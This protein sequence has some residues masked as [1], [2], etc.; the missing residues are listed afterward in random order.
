MRDLLRLYAAML[1]AS[2]A[3]QLQYRVALVIWLLGLVIQPVVYLVVWSAVAGQG[4]VGGYTRGD[5][6]AYYLTMMVVNHL[7][8]TWIMWEYD[9][10]IRQGQLSAMLLKPANPVHRLAADNMAYKLLTSVVVLPVAVLLGLY[11]RPTFVPTPERV[12]LFVA[13][14]TGAWVL[15]WLLEY[16]LALAAFWTTRVTALNELYYGLFWFLA[17]QVAP[18]A[19]LPGAVQRAAELLPFRYT[20]GF[21]VELLLGRLEGVQIAWGFTAQLVWIALAFGGYRLFW[22]AGLRRYSAVG[23]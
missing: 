4:A 9:Y 19:L 3:V 11:F 15:R 20:V 5:F 14:V 6:A 13:A 1:Q 10:L 12:V 23:G 7:T 2:I 16:T 8:F 17:G 21:P 22:R 18:N